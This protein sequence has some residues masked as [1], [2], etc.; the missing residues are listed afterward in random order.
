M[1]NIDDQT[2]RGFDLIWK[3]Y[4]AADQAPASESI[5]DTFEPFGGLKIADEDANISNVGEA[6]DRIYGYIENYLNGGSGATA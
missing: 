5:E 3:Q 6:V 4:G 1:R 2:A